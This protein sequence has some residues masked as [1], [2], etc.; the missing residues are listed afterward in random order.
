[1]PVS[2][3]N[4]GSSPKSA[5][6]DTDKLLPDFP[7]SG[8]RDGKVPKFS[9]N[10]LGWEEDS[11]TT[12][13]TQLTSHE[14][15]PNAH[16][17]I[18]RPATVFQE[19]NTDKIPASKLPDVAA[20]PT[21]T[22]SRQGTVEL[23]NS[24]E[25]DAGTD[26]SRVITVAQLKRYVDANAGSG[27]GGSGD[28]ETPL[29]TELYDN[30]RGV[31]FARSN[32]YTEYTISE[33]W[34]EFD[35]LEFVYREGGNVLTFTSVR[36]L[37]AGDS[38][39]IGTDAQISY[40]TTALKAIFMRGVANGGRLYTI[41]GVK[42]GSAGSG[43]GGTSGTDQ[44]ARD[45][46]EE[47]KERLDK[48]E[49]LTR[50]IDRIVDGTSWANAPAAEAQFAV[51]GERTTIGQKLL[52]IN[53]DPIDPAADIPS[54]T[55]WRTTLN[56][57]PNDQQI[58]VRIQRGLEPIQYR[59]NNSGA[60]TDLYAYDLLVNDTNWDYY[61]AGGA[62]GGSMALERRNETFHTAYH[63]DLA[64]NA[65]KS[66]NDLVTPVSTK[67]DTVETTANNAITRTAIFRPLS[68]W[69][70][71]NDA[72]TL[73]FVY[74]PLE[75]VHTTVNATV[76]IGGIT[77]NNVN[78][79]E[80]IAALDD[81]GIILNVP[82]T[83]QQAANITRSSSA[84]AGNVRCSITAGSADRITGWMRTESAP[85]T[86]TAAAPKWRL[87]TGSSPYTVLA[88]DDEFI[89]EMNYTINTIDSDFLA[90]VP[91]AALSTT[92]A[93]FGIN[94]DNRTVGFTISINSAGTELTVTKW[95]ASTDV[96]DS[97]FS[98][99]SIVNVF[100]R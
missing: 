70:L 16:P 97:R 62:G 4:V 33:N 51:F 83:A 9:G 63:G 31:S 30:V 81:V 69:E 12:V 48:V 38:T 89:I 43:G 91:K 32:T 52:R 44:T 76:V 54:D 25:V 85:A 7:A 45:G 88:T 39:T 59:L 56:P 11:D 77:I 100:A 57:V 28:G 18:P 5:T 82:I 92:A 74:R 72:R 35:S 2:N 24:A 46:V 8:S 90:S 55:V 42:K 10:D 73:Q 17:Q 65:L 64:G 99:W 15:D 14:S 86:S 79:T 95:R 96:N 34:T 94:G 50:D 6:V 71:T 67:V 47:N 21:A 20:V 53:R 66:V 1:M 37:D 22:E 75:A 27:G 3:P 58:L 13:S 41:Y 68:V 49:P 36:L 80:G 29:R 84:I 61:Q 23:A 78:P 98:R 60:I 19:G 26:P 87:L 40:R 93:N